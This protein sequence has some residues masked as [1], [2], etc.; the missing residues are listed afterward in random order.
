MTCCCHFGSIGHRPRHCNMFGEADDCRWRSFVGKNVNTCILRWRRP[1][2]KQD[3]KP[4][5]PDRIGT[6]RGQRRFGWPITGPIRDVYQALATIGQA[7][8][9][10]IKAE[11]VVAVENSVFGDHIVCLECGA[12]LKMLRRHL[13]RDHQMTPEEYRAKWNLPASFPMVAADYAAKRS[14]IA[15]DIGLGRKVKVVPSPQ[16]RKPGRPKRK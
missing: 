15:K 10:A 1:N 6:C 14:Q 16:K 3:H 11:P 5:C 13:A 2:E 4:Y 9:E 7:S 8:A 12:S